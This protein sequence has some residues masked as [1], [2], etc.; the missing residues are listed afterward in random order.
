MKAYHISQKKQLF[1]ETGKPIFKIQL[2]KVKA[3]PYAFLSDNSQKNETHNAG[4]I[5]HQIIIFSFKLSLN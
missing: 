4:H 5:K 3:A 2:R 1:A